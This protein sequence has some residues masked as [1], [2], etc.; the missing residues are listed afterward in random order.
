MSDPQALHVTRNVIPGKLG[1]DLHLHRVHIPLVSID[2]VRPYCGFLSPTREIIIIIIIIKRSERRKHCA[3][4]KISPHHR[5]LS[6]GAG[7]PKFNQLETV[8]AFTCRPSL[9]K[10]DACNF[11]LSW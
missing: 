4:A 8:T 7:R 10:I 5:P 1:V 2:V 9:V 6:G 11:D 3:S